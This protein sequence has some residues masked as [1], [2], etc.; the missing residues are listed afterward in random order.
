MKSYPIFILLILFAEIFTHNNQKNNTN[1]SQ[2]LKTF[3][4]KTKLSKEELEE[5]LSQSQT[6]FLY[7][8]AKEHKNKNETLKSENQNFTVEAPKEDLEKQIEEELEKEALNPLEEFHVREMNNDKNNKAFIQK[9]ENKII[10]DSFYE[11]K[12]GK[13][14][15]YLTLFIIVFL[16]IYFRGFLF[17]GKENIKK[18]KYKNLFESDANPNEYMLIKSE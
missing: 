15:A 12:Y 14:Y 1:H 18:N 10:V 3:I 2:E 16:I 5:L 11:R 17:K 13:S 8:R 6:A 4:V 9:E 7:L